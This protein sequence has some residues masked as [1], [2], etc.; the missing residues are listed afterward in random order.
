VKHEGLYQLLCAAMVDSQFC[1]I[2][3]RDPPRAIS[4]GY[5]DHTFSLTSE[6]WGLVVSLR[7]RELEDLASQIQSWVSTNGNGNG[8]DVLARM[9]RQAELFRD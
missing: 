2:L 9:S 1:E 3:L 7:A 5:L 8:H 6:E 4:G